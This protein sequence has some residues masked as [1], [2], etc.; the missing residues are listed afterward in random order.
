MPSG[1]ARYLR[2]HTARE[3]DVHVIH[4]I[5]EMQA[6]VMNAHAERQTVGCV[7]TMGALHEGHAALIS[8]S[9]S[10]HPLTVVSVF[11]NPLQFGPNEDYKRY[12]RDIDADVHII[13]A[14][15]GTHVFAPSVEEMYPD[16]FATS[17]HIGGVAERLEGASRPGHFD[18]VATVVCKLFQAMIPSEAFFGQ[19]DWQQTLV[20]KR[21]V[22]DLSLPVRIDVVPTIRDEDGL[23]KS[24]RN[25]YLSDADRANAL[26]LSRALHAAA[27]SVSNNGPSEKGSDGISSEQ[28][29]SIMMSTLNGIDVEY[30]VAVDSASLEPREF[31]HSKDS[32]ALLVAARVGTTRLIDNL[33]VTAP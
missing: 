32:I 5:A 1:L 26:S 4:T 14:H 18:G 6:V 30:A 17:I 8:R 27:E 25:K 11:V 9:A 20:I 29:E 24:S 16:G 10:R 19:K 7:P 31:F 12:P 21:M 15:G 33:V 23:A 28:L 3:R 2:G 22:K 13:R